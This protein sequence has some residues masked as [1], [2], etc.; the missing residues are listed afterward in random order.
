M[1][2][3]QCT[4]KSCNDL[5]TD[6]EP[7]EIECP[8]CNGQGCDDCNDGSVKIV[9]CPN[10]YC[11]PMIPAINLIDLFG[12]G[13]LP[14]AGGALDQSA[15]FLEAASVMGHEDAAMKAEARS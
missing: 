9:G 2:C 3:K 11:R 1:L 10:T 7:I 13:V 5:G 8:A 4:S 12:K 15:W 14:V 6:N